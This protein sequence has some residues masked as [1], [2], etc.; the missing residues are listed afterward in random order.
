MNHQEVARRS[1]QSLSRIQK[2][3]YKTPLLPSRHTGRENSCEIYF[4]AEN[5]QVT[6]SFKFRGALSKIT[7]Q[8]P[9]QRLVTA[10]SGN[11]GIGTAA[12]A[13]ILGRQLTVVL[14]ENVDRRK[15]EILNRYGVEVLVRGAE[16]GLAEEAAQKIARERGASYISPYNDPEIVSGQGTISLELQ[17]QIDRIDNIFVAMGG[18][19]LI[20]GVAS[21]LKSFSPVTRV[22][23]VSALN[24]AALNASIIAGRVVEVNHSDTIADAVAGS[25]MPDSITLPLASAAVDELL[26][27]DESEIADA[28]GHLS[29]KE[30]MIVEGAAALALAGFFKVE[31]RLRG[32][33][34]IVLLCGGNFD[35]ARILPLIA[36][37]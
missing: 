30:G 4:K 7:T 32:Q 26:L 33:V 17:D 18:G 19:G 35:P 11:H 23:G 13:S 27:C 25:V 14:P 16:T 20:S 3:I 5:F 31:E 12:A 24:S 37:C 10:S 9:M 36:R 15:Y 8:D 28:L 6:G 1:I 29:T 34:N 22:F 21:V 2:F